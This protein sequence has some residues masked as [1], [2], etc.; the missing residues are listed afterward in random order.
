[1]T[2]DNTGLD[3]NQLPDSD[4]GLPRIYTAFVHSVALSLC[5]ENTKES[6][7][8]SRDHSRGSNNLR[9]WGQDIPERSTASWKIIMIV[10]YS[11]THM[12]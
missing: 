10:G 4:E 3:E 11:N 7:D 2:L 5:A 1:M 8:C 6:A 12:S 9:N